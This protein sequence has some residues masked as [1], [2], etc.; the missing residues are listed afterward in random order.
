MS[1]QSRT[2]IAW[3]NMRARCLSPNAT[4]YARYGGRGITICERWMAGFEAFAEDMGDPG[5]GQSLDRIDVDG[6]YEPSNC[7]WASRVTQ[8]RNTSTNRFITIDGETRTMAE[9]CEVRAIRY[10]IVKYRLREGWSEEEAIF[11]ERRMKPTG[12]PRGE[13]CAAAK[14]TRD[15]VR[16]LRANPELPAT[17]AA[18]TLNVTARQVRNVRRGLSWAWLD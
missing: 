2:Y 3:K 5:P 16:W 8:A 14:L 7:R 9:W 13:A 11:P 10:G 6:H 12:S 4:G 17:M 18:R 15:Q 1:G